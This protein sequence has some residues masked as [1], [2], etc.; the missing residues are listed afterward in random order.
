MA[1]QRSFWKIAGGVMLFWL[2][3]LFYMSTSLYQTDD[4]ISRTQVQ[5]AKALR[6]LDHLKSQNSE[7][8]ALADSLR[9]VKHGF[10]LVLEISERTKNFK[11]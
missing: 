7:L 5:L 6:D 10:I 1:A 3:V 8:Q 9:Q 2:V 11:G 4:D